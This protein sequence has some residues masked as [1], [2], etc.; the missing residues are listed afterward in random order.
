MIT[1][2]GAFGLPDSSTGLTDLESQACPCDRVPWWTLLALG[3][4]AILI[5]AARGPRRCRHCE[6]K[7]TGI[8]GGVLVDRDGKSECAKNSDGHQT[9][10]RRH[11]PAT[12][13]D[14][15]P[16]ITATAETS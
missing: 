3:V 9:R 8:R 10:L 5:A 2:E 7:V 4:V 16:D 13:N 1:E 6:K 12:G 11:H 14:T 15:L